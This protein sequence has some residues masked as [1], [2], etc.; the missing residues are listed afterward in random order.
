VTFRL[1]DSLPAE[2]VERLKDAKAGSSVAYAR[3]IDAYLDRGSGAV[4]LPARMPGATFT[5]DP[6]RGVVRRNL[7]SLCR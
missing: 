5:G 1:F 2:V 4:W 7:F 3:Q 6:N